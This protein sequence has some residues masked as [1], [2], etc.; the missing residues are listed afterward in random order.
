[1]EEN[2][3]FIPTEFTETVIDDDENMEDDS[4]SGNDS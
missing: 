4:D 2:K 3:E 1:M